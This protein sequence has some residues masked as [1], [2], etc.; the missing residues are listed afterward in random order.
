MKNKIMLALLLLFFFAIVAHG[1]LD[2][3]ISVRI[4]PDD[5]N[6]FT[7][8]RNVNKTDSVLFHYWVRKNGDAFSRV[9]W[10]RTKKIGK[11]WVVTYGI[12]GQVLKNQTIIDPQ[13][14][15]TV[16][17]KFSNRKVIVTIP[18]NFNVSARL[19]LLV[20]TVPIVQTKIGKNVL[21]GYRG[22][23]I[24]SSKGKWLENRQGGT[25]DYA[26]TK[27]LSAGVWVYHN[28]KTKKFGGTYG[29][30]YRF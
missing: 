21:L 20:K 3:S 4:D 10:Q 28:D 2:N 17:P 13:A 18:F 12:G 16:A 19:P 5:W 25:I 26:F 11:N 29:A 24:R 27:K 22:E 8:T 15:V 1:Q 14:F 9:N 7:Y 6:Q 23:I 30:T